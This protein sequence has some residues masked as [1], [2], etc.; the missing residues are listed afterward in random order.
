MTSEPPTLLTIT[1]AI[2]IIQDN[3]ASTLETHSNCCVDNYAFC[4]HLSLNFKTL[5]WDLIKE[6]SLKS[7]EKIH[8]PYKKW[9]AI[10]VDINIQMDTEVV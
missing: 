4:S 2:I 8:K 6:F 7:L 10:C 9:L 1:N 5:I 3:N